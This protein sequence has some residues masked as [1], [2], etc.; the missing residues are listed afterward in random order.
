MK[1]VLD[2]ETIPIAESNCRLIEAIEPPAKYQTEEEIRAWREDQYR[3][4]ALDGTLGRI[5]CIALLT[6]GSENEPGDAYAFYGHNEAAILKRFWEILKGKI[7]PLIICHNGLSF[8]LPFIIKRSI[9]HQVKPTLMIN[10]AK[11]RKDHVFDTMAV[12]TNWE[13]RQGIKLELLSKVLGVEPKS[14]KGE[15]VLPLWK[16]GRYDEI[17]D[18]CLQDVYVTYSCYCRMNFFEPMPR[19]SFSEHKIFLD[20]DQEISC[21]P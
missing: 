10:M 6:L 1:I 14:G 4:T 3:L 12:W 20:N 11:Y 18:Y 17:A 13:Y 7:H 19:S 5:F 16:A 21:V 8:D 15:D 2:I 9:I